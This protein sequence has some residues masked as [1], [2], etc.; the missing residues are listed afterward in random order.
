MSAQPHTPARTLLREL[1]GGAL[2][3]GLAAV[4]VL[5]LCPLGWLLRALGV[6][7]LGLRPAPQ[8]SSYWRPG[9]DAPPPTEPLPP[10]TQTEPAP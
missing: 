3:G 1:L 7:L 10:A 9:P 6:D 2:Y 4:F 5:L 8:A